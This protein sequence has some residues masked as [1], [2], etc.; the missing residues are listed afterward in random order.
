MYHLNKKKTYGA[1]QK[2]VYLRQ[3]AWYNTSQIIIHGNYF[4]NLSVR[5]VTIDVDDDDDV[6]G[7]VDDDEAM[8]IQIIVGSRRKIPKWLGELKE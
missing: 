5:K 8:V 6:D 2:N 4:T 1:I 3:S 7:D